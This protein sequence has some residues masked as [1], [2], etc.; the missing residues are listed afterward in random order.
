MFG[1]LHQPLSFGSVVLLPV[2]LGVGSTLPLYVAVMRNQRRVVAMGLAS[3]GGFVALAVSPLPFVRELGIALA[4]G[5]LC[6]VAIALLLRRV[7]TRTG[8]IPLV[9]MTAMRTTPWDVVIPRT[10]YSRSTRRA[11]LV[12]LAL[13]AG[14]GW[15]VLPH[16]AVEANPLALAR[17]LPELDEALAA[18]QILGSSGE[19]SVQLR[20]PDVAS[21]EALDWARRAEAAV[22]AGYGD[23]AR[24]VLSLPTLLSFL[25][26]APT[27]EQIDAALDLFPSY[28]SSAVVTPDRRSAL[29][30]FGL[31]LADLDS[32]TQLLQQ[33]RDALPVP[34]PGYSADLVGLPVAADR[35]YELISGHRYLANLAGIAIAGIVLAAGLRRRTDALRAVGAAL[36]A[37]GWGLA[38][39]WATSGSL[40][41]LT[42]AFGS[43]VT[44]TGCEFLVLLAEASR[45]GELWL[46]RS[47][48]FACLTSA[49]GYAA[50][51]ASRLWLVREFGLVLTAA[52]LLSYLAAKAVIWLFPP[53]KPHMKSA[54]NPERVR[55][56]SGTEVT[57]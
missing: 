23:R 19:I 30:I 17:G 26:D 52:L 12:A 1:W 47:V 34:P 51:S 16:L 15:A 37:T 5:V 11:V 36:L 46:H 39:I 28:L 22:T 27:A 53:T 31:K 21:P 24:P 43:L 3:A 38:I 55:L 41:P 49:I 45:S 48:A 56:L 14:L 35:A 6:T 7:A 8:E 44:V 4:L 9:A 20:G 10:T 57:V 13:V 32:Q 33:V 25:G 18:E 29:L 40:S 54:S 50:L 42:V 2:L